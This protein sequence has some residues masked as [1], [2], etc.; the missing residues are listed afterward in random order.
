MAKRSAA[1]GVLGPLLVFAASCGVFLFSART[2]RL[3][4]AWVT[5]EFCQYAEI[6]KNLAAGGPFETRLV[7]PMALA[8]IDQNQKIGRGEGWP[9][10]NRYPLPCFAIAGLM[11]MTSSSA[12]AAAWS[13]GL[14]MS[15]LAALAF[16]LAR[17]W[18]GV[19]WAT[20][21]ALLILANPAFYGYFILLGT[22]DVWFALLFLL[23]LL[24]WCRLVDP[25]ES[26]HRTPFGLAFLTGS[27]AGLAY[28]SRQNALLFLVPQGAVLFAKRRWGAVAVSLAAA[29]LVT[30]PWLAYN[31]RRFGSPAVGIYSAWNL[32]DDIGAYPVEPWLYYQVPDL[33]A[34]LGSHLGGF[35]TKFAKNL[36]TVVPVRVWSL[37]HLEAILPLAIAGV[38]FA[39][40]GMSRI[41]ETP[42][43]FLHW[44]AGLFLIQL[45]CFSAL[46]LE[47]EDR[48][49][50]HHG[51]Y[52][53]W[54]AVPALLLALGS[55]RRLAERSR[56]WLILAGFVALVQF[57]QFGW[58]W[59]HWVVANR[60]RTNFG[61][62]PIRRA[63]TAIVAD[64]QVIASNQPQIT[65]WYS[66]RNSIS[67]P[68]DPDELERMNQRSPT[69]ADYIML[70]ANANFID[71]DP[72]WGVVMDPDP[73]DGPV[74]WKARLMRDYEFAIPRESTRPVGYVL[75]RR[76]T[77]APSRFER[78]LR[79]RIH[80]G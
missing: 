68:A 38:A 35:A 57:V 19:R 27:L 7:E 59:S 36:L 39:Q 66:G 65:A 9:V 6:G 43:R 26:T 56:R 54:F 79:E 52:F 73:P 17:Q 30:A 62:D 42:R 46:R 58:T 44:A 18:Y 72:R 29:F 47:L 75:L 15:G 10:I 37:W 14:A 40:P 21:A 5:F 28:L 13:N 41:E 11:W 61:H 24:A 1:G 64:D 33:G 45:V 32:L 77:I 4:P 16:L 55:L 76:R 51:R 67:L 2:I 12:M 48:A 25:R 8:Y 74:G 80:A 31:V 23:E 53:F 3:A 20:L 22:P 60:V 63:I 50:P 78:A 34:E 69:P 71:T 49:S 70:D